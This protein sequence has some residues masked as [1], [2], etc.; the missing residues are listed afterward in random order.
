MRLFP[1]ITGKAH[2]AAPGPMNSAAPGGSINQLNH[3]FKSFGWN[4][5]WADPDDVEG[6][7]AA[8]TPKTKA[9]FIESIANPGG[10]VTYDLRSSRA[11]KDAVE[12]AGGKAVRS[13][14]GHAHV[15]QQ[16]R[17]IKKMGGLGGV[18]S[19][20]PGIGKLKDAMAGAQMP[21]DSVVKRQEAIIL[22]MTKAERAKP[23][24]LNASRRRRIGCRC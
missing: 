20:M 17:Q 6:F 5:I 3:A 10:I 13:R 4:V 8:V 19:L 21:D 1:S 23:T 16:M 2:A 22:A 24:L 14:V 11:V 12:R 15:K 9:I 7:A 18:M